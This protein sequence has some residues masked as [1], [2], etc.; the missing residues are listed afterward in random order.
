MYI[1]ISSNWYGW[2]S[3]LKNNVLLFVRIFIL[4]HSL[5]IACQIHKQIQSAFWSGVFVRGITN[6]TVSFKLFVYFLFSLTHSLKHNKVVQNCRVFIQDFFQNKFS[7]WKPYTA[8]TVCKNCFCFK[9]NKENFLL[10][11]LSWG[12][13]CLSRSL[14]HRPVD[15]TH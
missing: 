3:C 1:V 10:K 5:G 7:E 15:N 4:I 6:K 14:Y 9:L 12:L 13:D 2:V 8:N 11:L